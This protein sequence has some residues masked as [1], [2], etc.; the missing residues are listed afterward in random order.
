MHPVVSILADNVVKHHLLFA[1][2]LFTILAAV[3]NVHTPTHHSL[4]V[5]TISWVIVWM[6]TVFWVGIYSNSSSAKR[7]ASWLA[8]TLLGLAHICDRA[9][10]DKEGIWATKVDLRERMPAISIL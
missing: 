7:R 5:T 4:L 9:A 2:L 10:C 3:S 8:G 1:P 6:P